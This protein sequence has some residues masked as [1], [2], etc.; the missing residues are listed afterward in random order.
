MVRNVL[1][2]IVGIVACMLVNGGI[3]SLSSTIIPPPPGVNLNDLESLKA[4]LHLFEAKHFIMPFVAH[5]M[6]SVVGGLLA[7]LIAAS[8]KMTF[9]LVIGIVHLLGGIA[10][11]IMIPSPMWFIVLD[12]VVAYVPMAWIGGK[13]G[14]KG[15][16]SPATA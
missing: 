4:H 2:V 10:A 11:A 5:A 3:I 14:S 1:A 8:R 12:L 9:A 16:S 7:A 13:L 6:G 15:G